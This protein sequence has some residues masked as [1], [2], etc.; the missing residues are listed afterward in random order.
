M[1]EENPLSETVSAMEY[2]FDKHVFNRTKNTTLDRIELTAEQVHKMTAH[3]KPAKTNA[4]RYIQ[5][6][7]RAKPKMEAAPMVCDPRPITHP[8]LVESARKAVN[9]VQGGEVVSRALRVCSLGDRYAEGLRQCANNGPMMAFFE[10]RKTYPSGVPYHVATFIQWFLD[11]RRNDAGNLNETT[12]L[13]I[14]LEKSGIDINKIADLAGVHR[15]KMA[16]VMSGKITDLRLPIRSRIYAALKA[17]K[18]LKK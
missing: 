3:M 7:S 8:Q 16:D 12:E 1:N 5:R 17:L 18:H 6:P 14:E 4:F 2:L 11:I 10:S 13:R 9:L 15:E